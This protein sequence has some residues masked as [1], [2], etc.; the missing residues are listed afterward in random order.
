MSL[1]KAVR[2]KCIDCIFNP[3][4]SG[5]KLQQTEACSCKNC[6]LWSYRPLTHATREL[7]SKATFQKLT[8]KQQAETLE[9]RRLV[10]ERFREIKS[11]N[12][13]PK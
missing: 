2:A 13:V 11:A 5:T 1:S 7:R 10:A 9:E 3:M 12:K 4:V 8:L 6:P